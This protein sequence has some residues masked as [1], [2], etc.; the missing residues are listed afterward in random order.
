LR[1]G[2]VDLDAILAELGVSLSG[3]EIALDDSGPRSTLRRQLVF[4]ASAAPSAP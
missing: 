1:P 4:G 3:E 2:E